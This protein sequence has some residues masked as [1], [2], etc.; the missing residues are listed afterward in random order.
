MRSR[1]SPAS[2]SGRHFAAREVSMTKSSK[3]PAEAQQPLDVHTFYVRLQTLPRVD[4]TA[5]DPPASR[6]FVSSNTVAVHHRLHRALE[7]RLWQDHVTLGGAS[8]QRVRDTHERTSTPSVEGIHGSHAGG[9]EARGE[10]GHPNDRT[11]GRTSRLHRWIQRPDSSQ[12]GEE[13]QGLE[14]PYRDARVHGEL[15]TRRPRVPR[16]PTQLCTT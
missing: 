8:R 10:D 1:F 12:V 13:R 9:R 15:G 6:P 5:S 4:P 2:V 16:V 11:K 14:K 7:A 3:P